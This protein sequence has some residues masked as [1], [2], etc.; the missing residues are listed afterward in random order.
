MSGDGKR[1]AAAG[2]KLPRPSSTLPAA[3]RKSQIDFRFRVEERL[4]REHRAWAESDSERRF[5]KRQH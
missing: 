3:H 4:S 5:G 2:P 1:S